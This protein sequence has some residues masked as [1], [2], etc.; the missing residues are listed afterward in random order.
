MVFLGFFFFNLFLK[1][2]LLSLWSMGR[3]KIT[4]EQVAGEKYIP[5]YI[6][7]QIQSQKQIGSFH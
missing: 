1:S 2:S 4:D 3:G 5:E 7:D 6:P